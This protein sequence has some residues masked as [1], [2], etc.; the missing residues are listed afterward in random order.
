VVIFALDVSGSMDEGQRRVA[1]QFFF[2]A[3][4]GLRRQ[5]AKVEVA[6]IAHAAEAWEFEESQF[7]Q[8]SSSGGTV[9]S[10]AFELA[11]ELL[12]G[13]YDAGR[14]NQYLF[15]ASDGENAAEDRARSAAALRT[16]GETVNYAGYVETG[17]VATFRPRDTQLTELFREMQAQG[18]PVGMSALGSQDDV[19]RALRE[20]FGSRQDE[21]AR[22]VR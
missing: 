17:G 1:K 3:L 21:P 19:W 16:L 4:Q 10:C 12:R 7:F 6:F 20:F 5:Y 9:S 8:A 18:L 11:G 14:Y 13:R 2:F 22:A 15:Y